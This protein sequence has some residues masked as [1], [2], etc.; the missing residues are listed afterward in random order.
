MNHVTMLDYIAATPAA[1]EENVRRS[2]E[3]TR[4]LT[5]EYVGNG[6]KNVWIVACGS[7]ANAAWCARPFVRRR[8]RCE[9]KIVTP[10]TFAVSEHDFGPEDMVLVV[11]QSGYSLNALSAAAVIRERGRRCLALTA[12]LQSDLAKTA[13]L[14]VDYG[15]GR[16]TVGYVTRGMTTL[17]L[18]FMLFA[19]ETARALGFDAPEETERLRSQLLQAAEAHRQVE[20]TWP[21]FLRKHYDALAAMNVTWWCGVGANLGTAMEGALK[22]SETMNIPAS[23]FETEEFIHG[24]NLQLTPDYTLF[25]LDGGAG[26][27]RIGQ[28]FDAACIVTEKAFLLTT[29]PERR[30]ER[31]FRVPADVPEEITPL[32]FLPIVQLTAYRF[33]EDLGRWKKHPLQRKMEQA[34]SSKSDN[35]SASSLNA[36][37]PER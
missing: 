29:D 23:A 15:G 20:R 18:F 26:S 36:D 27:R 31:V 34:L 25:F 2:R 10:F 32:C 24:P 13:D 7:S 1:M 16:E 6:Y 8:L 4:P 22:L 11:S 30:G 14:A 37:T 28:I 17:A 12:D 19:L 9:V 3:L 5:E 33:A 21:K 35:Y